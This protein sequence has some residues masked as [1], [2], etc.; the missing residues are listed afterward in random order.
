MERFYEQVPG[1]KP[2]LQ[3][4]RHHADACQTRRPFQDSCRRVL[5]GEARCEGPAC[6]A[7]TSLRQ[8]G[9]PRCG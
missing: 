9:D 6:G 7:H 3:Y 4:P 8:G 1:P 5:G 2:A